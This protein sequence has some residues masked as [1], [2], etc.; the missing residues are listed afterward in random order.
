MLVQWCPNFLSGGLD[1]QCLV[2]PWA[3]SSW[4]SLSGSHSG[5]SRAPSGYI[6]GRVGA[7]LGL[8]EGTR[9]GHSLAPD[10]S[11]WEGKGTWP[12]PNLT[13]WGWRGHG[14]ALEGEEDLAHPQPSP[15]EEVQNR[16]WPVPNP[17]P[18]SWGWG[19][20]V[21][22]GPEGERGG[23]RMAQPQWGRGREH[24]PAPNWPNFLTYGESCRLDAMV[25]NPWF[26]E[27]WPGYRSSQINLV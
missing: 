10:P 14:P 23:Q 8:M 24:G 22:P 16:A 11:L 2:C 13:P 1:G 4:W 3:I 19:D 9:E 15:A 27:T 21:W 17:S 25:K 12:S 6:G 26:S 18:A 20:G 7:R 5:C